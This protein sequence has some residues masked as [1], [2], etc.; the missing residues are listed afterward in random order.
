MIEI[1]GLTNKQKVMLDVLWSMDSYD[2]VRSW[3]SSLPLEDQY[4][5]ETLMELVALAYIDEA[6]NSDLD[7]SESR[8][9]MRKFHC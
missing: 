2:E 8:E 4:V 6:V 7:M 3:Q 5:V 9:I 1:H